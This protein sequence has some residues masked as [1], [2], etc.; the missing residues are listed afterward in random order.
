[1]ETCVQDI[2]AFAWIMTAMRSDSRLRGGWFGKFRQQ[3]HTQVPDILDYS[4]LQQ[5]QAPIEQHRE[6]ESSFSI[7]P[8]DNLLQ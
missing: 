4:S 1:M 2:Y 7:D 3:I 8:S 5:P 6:F